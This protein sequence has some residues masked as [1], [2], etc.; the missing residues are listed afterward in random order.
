MSTPI[1]EC[2]DSLTAVAQFNTDCSTYLNAGGTPPEL[3]PI[4]DVLDYSESLTHSLN[5]P[6]S[7]GEFST[8]AVQES[9]S[10]IAAVGREIDMASRGKVILFLGAASEYA[11]E[12]TFYTQSRDFYVGVM[13]G[14]PTNGSQC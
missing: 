11:D 4:L 8:G 12:A 6:S 5:Q 7:S 10:F 9:M 1:I 3:S 14:G 2:Q 13:K